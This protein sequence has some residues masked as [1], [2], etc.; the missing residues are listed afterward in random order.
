MNR[1][2]QAYSQPKNVRIL[3]LAGLALLTFASVYLAMRF[4]MTLLLGVPVGAVVAMQMVYSYRPLFYLM[5]M[6][7]PISISYSLPGGS[8]MQFFSEL[9]MIAFLVVFIINLL[10]GK[11]FR[12]GQRIYAFHILIA[13]LIFWTVV[14]SINSTHPGR[15]FKFLAARMWYL[16]AFV[17][18]AE[19]VLQ[20]TKSIKN[21]LWCFLSTLLIVVLVTT[22][23]HSLEGFSFDSSNMVSYPFY[24]NHVIYG[25]T[26]TLF[27]PFAWYMRQWYTP[28]SLLWYVLLGAF[29][30]LL[31]AVAIS[32]ARGA[33]VTCAMLPFIAF[34]I[35]RKWFV[36]AVYAGI[37]LTILGVTYL[38]QDNTYYRYAPEFKKT[39]FHEGDLEGHLTATFEGQ[40]MSTMERFFR[41]VAAIHMIEERP[42]LG[43]GPSS[44]NQNYKRYADDAFRT[45]VSDNPEQSTT[46]NYFLM[47]FA[48]QGIF[49][50][51]LFLFICIF[52]VIKGAKLYHKVS[53]KTH[54]GLLAAAILSLCV[55]ICH[56]ALNELIEVDKVGAMFWLNLVIIHKVEVWEEEREKEPL[57]KEK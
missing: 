50:G 31:L 8:E 12:K 53:S 57:L 1:L 16:A 34:A 42:M 40:E 5:V 18:M 39:I 56:S 22:L 9:M 54:Q 25:A 3:M 29:G 36:P 44:F 15:S 4:R 17:F 38:L 6:G 30:L 55:I 2:L 27:V 48:E 14:T 7:V 35:Q 10:A 21:L 37:F 45:Y 32:Y 11:Q 51:L 28:K 43:F 47:T 33:W 20:D 41:W 23:R 49:G 19:K 46:H 52:M 26:V 24:A 13:L